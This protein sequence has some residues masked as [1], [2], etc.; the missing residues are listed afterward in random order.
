MLVVIVNTDSHIL[1]LI[2][3]YS[4]TYSHISSSTTTGSVTH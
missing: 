2:K 3:T 4:S 1:V